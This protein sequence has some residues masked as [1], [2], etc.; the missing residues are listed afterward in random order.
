MRASPQSGW[1]CG[2]I[3]LEIKPSDYQNLPSAEPP[4]QLPVSPS[5]RLPVSPSPRLPVS[6]SPRLPVSP[7]PRLPVSPRRAPQ[8]VTADLRSFHDHL[9]VHH[10]PVSG[11][12][13][14]VGVAALLLGRGEMDD[15]LLLR[16]GD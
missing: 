14:E 11:E 4:I 5:P 16:A 6:P 10:H 1:E 12:G 15:E 8:R 7:S 2:P 13:A 9:S 3:K